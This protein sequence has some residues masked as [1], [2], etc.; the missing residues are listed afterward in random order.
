MKPWTKEGFAFLHLAE[1]SGLIRAIE[2]QAREE[3]RT[4][5]DQILWMLLQYPDIAAS[6]PSHAQDE[7]E[8]SRLGLHDHPV[9]LTPPKKRKP[10]P[11]AK[12]KKPAKKI[13]KK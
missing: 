9:P 6:L 5:H 3:F 10:R 8:F 13:P 11:K 12:A 2:V 7:D 1:V 4:P